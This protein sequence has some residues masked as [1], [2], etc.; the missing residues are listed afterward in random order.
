MTERSEERLKALASTDPLT[1]IL[2]RR[3]LIDEFQARC[4]SVIP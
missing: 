1:G 3:G 2:N 4:S